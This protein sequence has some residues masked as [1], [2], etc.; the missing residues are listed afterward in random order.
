M[1]ILIMLYFLF[2]NILI[3]KVCI[4]LF[5]LDTVLS[6][7]SLQCTICSASD[8]GWLNYD[9]FQK[10]FSDKILICCFYKITK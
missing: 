3:L 2:L 6:I 1:Y 9:L 8:N 4:Y 7:D 5:V 10:T